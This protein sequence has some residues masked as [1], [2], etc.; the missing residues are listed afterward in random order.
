MGGSDGKRNNGVPKQKQGIFLNANL[1]FMAK[2]KQCGENKCNWLPR[3]MRSN[4]LTAQ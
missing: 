4:E 1:A 3:E 2:I